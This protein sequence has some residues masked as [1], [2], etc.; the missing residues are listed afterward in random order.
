MRQRIIENRFLKELTL[1]HSSVIL[2][3]TVTGFKQLLSVSW[4]FSKI[5]LLIKVIITEINIIIIWVPCKQFGMGQTDTHKP[6]G[7]EMNPYSF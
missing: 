4:A 1:S 6:V 2:L 3:Y 7:M 5:P